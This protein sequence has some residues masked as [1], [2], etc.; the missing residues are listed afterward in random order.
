MLKH[1]PRH[2]TRYDL[3]IQKAGRLIDSYFDPMKY[4]LIVKNNNYPI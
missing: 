1:K 2:G 4:V 3:A